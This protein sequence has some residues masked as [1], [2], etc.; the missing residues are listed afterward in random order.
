MLHKYTSFVPHPTTAIAALV[1]V[2]GAAGCSSATEA[3]SDAPPPTTSAA[4]STPPQ[5]LGRQEIVRRDGHDLAFYLTPGD[6]GTIV[7]DAGGGND[8]TYWN[9][10]VPDLAA[11]TG[12]AIVT[13]DRTGAGQSDDVP[14]AFDPSAAGE[15]LAAGL[16][17]LDLPD[18]PV[19]LAGHSI[20]GEV[21][22]AL[23][24]THPDIVDGAVLI[25]A[26][27]PPF[28]TP[29]QITRLVAANEEKVT[30]IK[31]APSTRQSRQFLAV[32][33]NW[34]PVHTAFHAM[35]WPQDIPVSVIVSEETPMPAGSADARNWTAAA[36]LFV[37]QG[38][39]RHL[40]TAVGSSHD[41]PLDDPA[42]VQ[43]E[44][45]GMFD[46]L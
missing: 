29:D 11:A 17:S 46:A 12:A 34:G 3:P 14:G 9:G 36:A 28:F 30:A 42:L 5:A 16:E 6:G 27:L 23:V 13:Y 20:A 32:A 40:V 22:H 41:V 21:A 39:N 33:E 25:D 8:A 45:T 38:P 24:N 26:N 19:V 37:G 35:T 1:V 2:L 31:S 18:G 43:T 7:L 10:I 44:I 15:D 4:S